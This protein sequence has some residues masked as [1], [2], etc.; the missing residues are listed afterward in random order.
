ME[1]DTSIALFHNGD[2]QG[3]KLFCFEVERSTL[4]D[5]LSQGA[6][7]TGCVWNGFIQSAEL[8]AGA[9]KFGL[10]SHILILRCIFR[11]K[12]TSIACQL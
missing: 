11:R 4:F 8:I 10:P 3:Y 2:T 9:V 1:S 12:T 7:S 6:E 5:G